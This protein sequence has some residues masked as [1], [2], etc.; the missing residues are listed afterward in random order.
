MGRRP[1][2]KR[3]PG[4]GALSSFCENIRKKC[5]AV[6]LLVTTG[7]CDNKMDD[8]S[9]FCR[10]HWAKSLLWPISRGAGFARFLLLKTPLSGAHSASCNAC[11]SIHATA[12]HKRPQHQ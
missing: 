10:H 3:K 8:C 7:R 1:H 2:A 12:K 4:K 9:T 11:E 5:R 6:G